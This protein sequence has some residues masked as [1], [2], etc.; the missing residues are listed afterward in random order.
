MPDFEKRRWRSRFER[1]LLDAGAADSHEA[2][3][4]RKAAAIGAMRGTVVEFGPGTGVNMRY[5]APGVHVIAIEPNPFMHERLRVQAQEHGVDLEIRTLRGE[6]VDIEDASVNGVVGTLLL[7]G[8]DDPAAVISEA[9]RVLAPG[10]TYFFLEHV[11]APADSGMRHVQRLVKRPHEWLLNGC[12]IDQDSA[13]LLQA[14]PFDSV[15]VEEIDRG[16]A[17]AWCR[18]Q[19]IGTAA[20]SG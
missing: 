6:S 16:R 5:F 11:H 20:K 18:H 4:E 3:G 17:A 1:R 9:H 19:I 14:G 2:L 12:R 13:S 7:C 10:G 8:V 15:D